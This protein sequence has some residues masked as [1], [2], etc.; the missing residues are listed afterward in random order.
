MEDIKKLKEIE[1]E[2][3]RQ[4]IEICN[5][6]SLRY[7]VVG[8][9]ALGAVRHKGFIPWD[10]DIDVA[11]PRGDY[12]KF[13]SI[14]Q[15]SLPGNMFLQTYITDKNYP[16]PFAKLRRSDTAFIEK[17]TSKIKMNHGVYIDIFPL[18]GYSRP[19]IKGKLFRLKEKILKISVGS[20]FVSGNILKNKFRAIVKRAIARLLPDYRA[21]VRRLDTMYKKIPYED[22]EII[23]NFCGAWAEKEIMPKAYFGNG[24]EGEFEGIKVVLPA[25]THEYLTALYG[26]YMTLPPEE[27]RVGHH[28][29]TVIDLEKSYKEYVNNA[30]A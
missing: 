6:N 21:S 13:L 20:V 10:D 22:A 12:E 9:T 19:G 8:G 3:F 16:N 7:F 29:Y 15:S 30:N 5:E 24:I 11:L 4:F 23:V 2:I 27:E 17:S 1:L 26:D 14:A 28:Y 18:D 25:K